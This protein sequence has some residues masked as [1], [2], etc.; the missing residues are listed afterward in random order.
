MV[1]IIDADALPITFD[2]NHEYVEKSDIDDAPTV[3]AIPIDFI[4]NR[5]IHLQM[6]M[7]AYCY[8][9]DPDYEEGTDP[10]FNEIFVLQ[11]LVRMWEM[12]NNEE[13]D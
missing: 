13:T 3:D 12:H 10:L 9:P 4:N 5:I 1:R 7:A 8:P 2:G 11:R 6:R